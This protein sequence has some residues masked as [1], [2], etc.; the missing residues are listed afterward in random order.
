MRPALAC[1]RSSPAGSPSLI[2]CQRQAPG[3]EG[4]VLVEPSVE[5]P[6]HREGN[7]LDGA[8]IYPRLDGGDLLR[9]L[10]A[11]AVPSSRG[12]LGTGRR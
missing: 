10:D 4:F 1:T 7:V 11:V 12:H 9:E 8:R 2:T 3:G 6:E 5:I